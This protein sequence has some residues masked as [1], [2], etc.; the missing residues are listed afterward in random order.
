[1]LARSKLPP[2]MRLLCAAALLAA[3]SLAAGAADSPGADAPGPEMPTEA[4]SWQDHDYQFNYMGFTAIYSCDGLADKLQLLLRLSGAR[5]DAKVMPSCTR[6]FGIPDRL[7]QAH[8]KFSTLQP[9]AS[10]SSVDGVWRHV[11]LSAHHPFDLHSGD[12]ELVE[13]FRDRL[14]PMFATRNLKQQITCVPHQDSG[15]NFSMSFDV[16]APLPPPKAT[17]KPKANSA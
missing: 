8:V 6:G 10:D 17:K 5:A 2:A 7:A 9:A 4:G 13:Q 11:E 1:M 16:F 14:L 12:C 3:M 15:S